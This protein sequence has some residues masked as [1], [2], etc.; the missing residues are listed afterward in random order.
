YAGK[1]AQFTVRSYSSLPQNY[2]WYN[3]ST[4]L[5]GQTGAS[6]TITNVQSAQAG[7]YSVQISNS[8]GATNSVSVTLAVAT[9]NVAQAAVTP[10]GQ[11]QCTVSGI[12]G[13][14]A[15]V[16]WSDNVAGPWQSLTNVTIGASGT[17]SV[18][19]PTTPP[20][21]TRFYRVLFP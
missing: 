7:N 19:D 14:T 5:A 9:P 6:L 1:T 12:A 21:A 11:F 3:G 16:L 20:P 17:V 8:L 2:Q 10:G 4:L 15:D 18:Q 13:S